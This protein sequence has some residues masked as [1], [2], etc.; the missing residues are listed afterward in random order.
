MNCYGIFYGG[1]NYSTMISEEDVEQ[2]RSIQSAKDTFWRRTDFDPYYPC[3][4]DAEM[5]LF[6]SYPNLDDLY[7]DRIIRLGKRGGV[8]C[9]RV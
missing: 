7:P 1:S 5:H 9:E 3:V 8:Y 6:F 4:E 2:F